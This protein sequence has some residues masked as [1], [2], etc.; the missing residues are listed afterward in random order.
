[1]LVIRCKSL[2]QFY[3]HTTCLNSVSVS[4]C[5]YADAAFHA[6]VKLAKDAKEKGRRTA[7]N[8]QLQKEICELY[9]DFYRR[10]WNYAPTR[11]VLSHV[12]NLTIWYLLL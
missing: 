6:G 8:V 4:C 2:R 7:D 1:M 10:T 11:F 3:F 5:R 9:R 12:P